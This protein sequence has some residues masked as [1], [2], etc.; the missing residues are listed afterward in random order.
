MSKIALTPNASGT[1]TF[2]IASPN[3][4]TDRT[5]TLPDEAG[6]VLTS[7]STIDSSKVLPSG[8]TAWPAFRLSLTPDQDESA[9]NVEVDVVWNQSSGENRYI[10]GGMSLSSG[11]ITVPVDG[12]YLFSVGLRINNIGSGYVIGHIAKNNDYTG[13]S[14]LYIIDGN[15]PS[16][17]VNLTGSTHFKMT[18]GDNVR[19]SVFVQ[20][21]TSWKVDDNSVFSGSLIAAE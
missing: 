16:D 8:Q 15:P 7:A 4:N 3:S 9:T 18:A 12:I 20:T 6:T 14:E 11:V 19:A 13:Q 5:L 10:Q 17:Y 1:G 21:D 2:T